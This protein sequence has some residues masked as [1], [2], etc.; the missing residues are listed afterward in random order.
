MKYKHLFTAFLF[1]LISAPLAAQDSYAPD[2]PGIANG[3]FITPNGM[4]GL[5][6]G[7]QFSSTPFVDQID[8]G[9][10]L[11]RYGAGDRLELRAALN[12]FSFREIEVEG[13]DIS[14]SGIQDFAIGLKYNVL[15][16]S[17]NSP[18]LSLL[19][20]LSLPTGSDAFSSGDAVPTFG[21]LMDH[22]ISPSFSISS[23]LAYSFETDSNTDVWLF[24]VTPGFVIS[25][26]NNLSGYFGYAGN[27]YGSGFEDHILEGG[28]V[29]GLED[30]SQLDF[31]FGF[32]AEDEYFF[33]GAG[34]AQ[35]F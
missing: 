28:L 4:L 1:I 8:I 9:Q 17:D 13:G 7:M 14:D 18:N 33:V 26:E 30:G 32:D 23:N 2:R 35:G 29:Y 12:S 3:S 27:Y 19:G 25:E 22:S 6:A 21:L 20:N 15:Q 34:F 24:T 16:G 10:V 5:E 11:L 31:N